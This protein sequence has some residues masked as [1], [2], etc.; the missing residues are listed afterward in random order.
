MLDGR[1]SGTGG[2]NH[3]VLG[4][5]APTDSPFLRRPICCDR[6]SY[7]GSIIR[8]QLSVQRD[9]RGADKPGSANRRGAA[10]RH[11]RARYC[12]R[13]IDRQLATSAAP[14]WMVDRVFRHLLVDVT[15]NTHRA[16]FCIDKLFSPDTST[17]RLGLVE[18]RA[19][20]MP[21]HS[22]MNLTQ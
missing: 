12:L 22:R 16:E 20:E 13:Q 9:V 5:A 19:F 7:I 8:A 2:G 18:F 17:G 14:P 11:L 4:G 1:H 10:R 6:S 21:P 3:V 15:G